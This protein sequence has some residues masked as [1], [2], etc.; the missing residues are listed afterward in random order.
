MSDCDTQ[1]DNDRLIKYSPNLPTVVAQWRVHFEYEGKIYM[2]MEIKTPNLAGVNELGD[3]GRFVGSTDRFGTFTPR[4]A[5]IGHLTMLSAAKPRS[6]YQP[7]TRR[8]DI[9]EAKDI[10][11]TRT[12]AESSPF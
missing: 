9:R 4:D 6:D 5:L 11:A 2:L 10:Y 8:I 3:Y 7:G 1:E 12:W